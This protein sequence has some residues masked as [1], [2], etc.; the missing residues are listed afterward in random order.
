MIDSPLLPHLD[1]Y[2]DGCWTKP[3]L[4]VPKIALF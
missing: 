2:I 4:F 3:A 1:A